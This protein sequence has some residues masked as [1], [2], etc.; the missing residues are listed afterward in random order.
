MNSTE[1]TNET[2]A[3]P[4]SRTSRPRVITR[5]SAIRHLIW[6]RAENA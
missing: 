2:P 1:T 6:A 3:M 4:R 5:L